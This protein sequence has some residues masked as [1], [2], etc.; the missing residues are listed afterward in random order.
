MDKERLTEETENAKN[1]TFGSL[2]VKYL[3]EDTLR[4]W[5]NINRA[6]FIL[7]NILEVNGEQTKSHLANLIRPMQELLNKDGNGAQ[8]L[9]KKLF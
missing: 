5:L 9:R 4:I 6:C 1:D 7:L 8:L 3:N 2:L